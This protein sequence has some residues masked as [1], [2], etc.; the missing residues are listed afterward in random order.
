MALNWFTIIK[1]PKL[2]TGSKLTTNL[3]VDNKEENDDCERKIREY[4]DKLDKM[5]NIQNDE[6]RILTRGF[7]HSAPIAVMPVISEEV[8]CKVLK[9][10]NQLTFNSPTIYEKFE[11]EYGDKIRIEA[12][13]KQLPKLKFPEKKYAYQNDPISVIMSITV[14]YMINYSHTVPL[15]LLKQ[16]TFS[17]RDKMEEYIKEVDFR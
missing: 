9:I 3:G 2:R 17:N 11:N 15:A 7:L 10:L 8:Y 5:K 16:I 12:G 1:N 14:S 13:Y 6:V 4:V